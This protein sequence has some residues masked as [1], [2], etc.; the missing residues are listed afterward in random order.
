MKKLLFLII[1]LIILGYIGYKYF[2]LDKNPT[3][4]NAIQNII[5]GKDSKEAEAVVKKIIFDSVQTKAKE[6]FTEHKNR[7]LV[8]KTNNICV[9]IQS[10]L[11]GNEELEKSPI[12][13]SAKELTF[14][15]RLRS[16]LTKSYYCADSTGIYTTALEESGFEEGVKCE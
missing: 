16:G 6:Y 14:T 5:K 12:E 9:S 13:C 3:F 10:F 8:S 11:A 15:A 1:G 7:Y 2:E 4:N